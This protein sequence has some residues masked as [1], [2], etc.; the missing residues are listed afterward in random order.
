MASTVYQFPQIF[1]N[2]F[3][4]RAGIG[5]RLPSTQSPHPGHSPPP[6]KPPTGRSQFSPASGP[7]APPTAT[8]PPP[9]AVGLY[10]ARLRAPHLQPS[11]ASLQ[12]QLRLLSPRRSSGLPVLHPPSPPALR[13]VLLCDSPTFPKTRSCST[14]ASGSVPTGT[15]A[16][17]GRCSRDPREQQRPSMTLDT[18]EHPQS[19]PRRRRND[20]RDP[21]RNPDSGG[22]S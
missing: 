19:G 15:P 22:R 14:A 4:P 18:R 13:P 6:G 1:D 11:R 12:G 10:P 21:A 7:G 3:P 2:G 5:S 17:A 9:R 16:G 20:R 8:M